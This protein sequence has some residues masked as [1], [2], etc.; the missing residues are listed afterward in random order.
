MEV[1]QMIGYL[2]AAAV[3]SLG[4][5]CS[6]SFKEIIKKFF[7]GLSGKQ[8]NLLFYSLLAVAAYGAYYSVNITTNEKATK[9]IVVTPKET[10]APH[11]KSDVE[12]V[13]E[14]APEIIKGISTGIK[15][16]QANKQKKDSIREANREKMWVYQVG[17]PM[18]SEKELWKAYKALKNIPNLFVFEE[19]RKSFILIKDGKYHS[20]E[21]ARNGL[22]SFQREVDQ[23]GVRIK[24]IDL[25]SFCSKRETLI[26][27]DNMTAR[28]EEVEIPC[29]ACN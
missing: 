1:N 7:S 28:K 19:S 27:N 18:R 16:I 2:S 22:E 5:I 11:V 25:L 23:L 9:P 3:A 17:L 21:E 24:V 8:I 14:A 12:V 29:F 26:Q 6:E 13:A 20:E 4:L 15:T 10:P